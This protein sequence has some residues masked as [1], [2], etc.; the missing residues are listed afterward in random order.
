MPAQH[1]GLAVAGELRVFWLPAPL[2]LLRE[3][4]QALQ[5]LLLEQ[6]LVLEVAG[7]EVLVE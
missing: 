2:V 1:A 6:E 7:A 5:L 4:A 3:V